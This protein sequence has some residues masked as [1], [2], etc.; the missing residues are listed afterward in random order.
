MTLQPRQGLLTF[1]Y[2]EIGVTC[3]DLIAPLRLPDSL[4]GMFPK[5]LSTFLFNCFQSRG[6]SDMGDLEDIRWYHKQA[7]V[8][9]DGKRTAQHLAAR[10]PG[11][12]Y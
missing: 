11:G 5:S 9:C 3:R 1:H 2:S 7:L 6:S 10:K 8:L 4:D 12:C